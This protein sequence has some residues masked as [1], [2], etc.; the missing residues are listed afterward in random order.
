MSN[1]KSAADEKNSIVYR[2]FIPFLVLLLIAVAYGY[3]LSMSKIF[4]ELGMG[5]FGILLAVLIALV[6]VPLLLLFFV[7][8][9]ALAFATYQQR[10]DRTNYAGIWR[11][12][13]LFLLCFSFSGY[14][15]LSSAIRLIEGPKVVRASLAGLND[16]FATL[17]GDAENILATPD[18]DTLRTAIASDETELTNEIINRNGGDNCGI[19]DH[20]QSIIADIEVKLPNFRLPSGIDTWDHR[21]A[22]VGEM[23]KINSVVSTA[24]DDALNHAPV[25]A[26]EQVAEKQNIGVAVSTQISQQQQVLS[27][28]LS[29]LDASPTFV[30][31]P[32]YELEFQNDLDLAS[33]A[34]DDVY[35]KLKVVAPTASFQAPSPQDVLI[36]YI[37]VVD[38]LVSPLQ[39]VTAM[40]WLGKY[41]LTW[42]FL[43]AALAFDLV[44]C[45]LAYSI[46]K[47]YLILTRQ[48]IYILKRPDKRMGDVDYIWSPPPSE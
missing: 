39:I 10:D 16:S 23:N 32:Q 20:A 28:D 43:L 29:L 8:H 7:R 46:V 36:R 19:K 17:S 3:Y 2:A 15:V 21:C 26:S 5:S 37:D 30:F 34:Y 22:D 35:Q 44:T 42:F 40:P 41:V 38:N 24:I 1:A 9:T 12:L 14:G 13:V 31:H 18:W 33:A 27:N 4:T 45:L 48:R 11:P 25:Y 47:R 6:P